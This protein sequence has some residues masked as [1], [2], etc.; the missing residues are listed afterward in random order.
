[1][2][3]E[4]YRFFMVAVTSGQEEH[5]ARI[6]ELRVINSNG[7][8]RIKSIFKPPSM[9]GTLVVEASSYTDVLKGFENIK[10]FKKIIPGILS[11]DDVTRLLEIGKEEEVIEV[12]D[13]V[14]I[15]S[16]PFR[17]MTAKVINIRG[18]KDR[19]GAVIQLQDPSAANIPVIV[20]LSSLKKKRD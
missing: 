10:Y 16:G 13:I 7:G 3:G 8:I 19:K 2:A 9:R 18:E 14:E 11:L 5:I 20:P 4:S 17:G 15:I 12:G 6:V 1:M